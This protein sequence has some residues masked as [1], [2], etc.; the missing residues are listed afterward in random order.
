MDEIEPDVRAGLP[1]RTRLEAA[2]LFVFD[3][4]RWQL[5][6]SFPFAGCGDP[7]PF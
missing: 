5:R 3:G 7:R 4:A 2:Q 6:H 1:L